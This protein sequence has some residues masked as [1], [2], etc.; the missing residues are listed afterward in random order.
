[1]AYS[2][3]GA[4]PF[5]FSESLLDKWYES[6]E[7]RYCEECLWY[8]AV[9]MLDGSTRFC[10]VEDCDDAFELDQDNTACGEFEKRD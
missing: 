9:K 4:Y 3:E 7:G 6:A 10:C 5:G 1:M 8:T 2:D